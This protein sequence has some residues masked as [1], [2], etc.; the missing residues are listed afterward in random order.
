MAK[1]TEITHLVDGAKNP[2]HR[3]GGDLELDDKD[4]ALADEL[5]IDLARDTETL[6]DSAVEK[7]NRSGRLVVE[8]GLELLAAKRARA[9][10]EWY[11][12]LESRGLTQQR[13][14]EFM[15]YAKF[16]SRL[17][18]AERRKMLA[19]PKKKVLVLAA[20][21]PETIDELLASDDEFDALTAL[22]PI[23]L[24]RKVKALESEKRNLE[25][26]LALKVR[27]VRQLHE[28]R[29]QHTQP[30][31]EYVTLARSEANAL[32][33]KARLCLDDLA[34]IHADHLARYATQQGDPRAEEYWDTA[35]AAIY[36]NTRAVV[37]QATALIKRLEADLP[38]TITGEI[39]GA[40]LYND[41]DIAQAARDRELLVQLH[42]HERALRAQSRPQPKRGPG[43]PRKEQRK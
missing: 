32:A 22:S 21:E 31:P 37:A 42:A 25:G 16:A 38:P 19:L 18:A 24:R 5:S 29:I 36:H 4:A 28:Q 43:R 9:H 8:V 33:E 14:S 13:A 6:L 7:A 12:L 35:A 15:R 20:A 39:T 2:N 30:Y 10:G 34:Q 40:Y 1:K 23:E 27:E 3:L 17:P 11:P 26:H 41:E